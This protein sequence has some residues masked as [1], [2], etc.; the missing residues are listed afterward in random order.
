MH[1][2]R[3]TFNALIAI[4]RNAPGANGLNLQ[5]WLKDLNAE[6]ARVWLWAGMLEDHPDITLEQVGAM[7]DLPAFWRIMAAMEQQ[8]AE[9]KDGPDPNPQPAAS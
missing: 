6:K 4:E 8:A 2:L 3:F 7:F 1:H 5:P 9:I